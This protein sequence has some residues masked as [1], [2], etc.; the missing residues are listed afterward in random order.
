MRLV[1]PEEG[2]LRQEME[3]RGVLCERVDMTH[4][5]DPRPAWVLRRLLRRWDPDIVQSHGAR[6]NFYTR[7]AAGRAPLISTIHN[8]LT[9]YPVS[10]W[11]KKLYQ[12]MDYSTAWRSDRVVCV[13]EALRREVTKRLPQVSPRAMVIHNGVD[14]ERFNPARYDRESIRA[15]LGLDDLWTLGIVGRMTDQ[16]GHVFLF[17]ALANARDILPPYRLLVVG[18][19]PRRSL[20]EEKVREYNLT[21]SVQFLGVRHDIPEILSALDALIMPSV[22]EGFPYVLLEALAMEL[23]VVASLVK[24]VDEIIRDG[25]EGYAIVPRSPERILEALV[26]IWRQRDEARRRAKLG[27]C[28]VRNDFSIAASI[29]KWERLYLELAGESRSAAQTQ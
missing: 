7:L 27:R 5:G 29:Q 14:L 21:G 13:A 24:G 4:L 19:G 8:A 18:D 17:E 26:A 9:D 15:A 16:K 10:F 23:P 11:R 22:S 12:W 20:L 2:P 1:I 28:R 25:D 6:P 3:K